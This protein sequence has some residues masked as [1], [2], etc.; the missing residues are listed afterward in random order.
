[1]LREVNCI[2]FVRLRTKDSYW[3][4]YTGLGFLIT[5]VFGSAYDFVETRLKVCSAVLG[6]V[7]PSISGMSGDWPP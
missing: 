7:L 3:L 5:Q 2:S 6:C 4:A 1:M